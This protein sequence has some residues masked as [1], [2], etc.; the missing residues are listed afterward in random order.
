MKRKNLLQLGDV[1][2]TNPCVGWYG[3]AVVLAEWEKTEQFVPL[4]HIGIVDLAV[5]YKF[6]LSETNI[7]DLRILKIMQNIRMS[8]GEYASLREAACIGIYARKIDASIDV[9]GNIEIS[10]FWNRP[11]DL[12]VGDG[13]E[14]AFP[15]CGKIPSNLGYEAVNQWREVNDKDNWIIECDEARRSH[16]EMLERLKNAKL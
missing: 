8:T 13:S 6:E 11:L 7:S 1:I 15:L 2:R 5:K 10:G 9:I 16:Q 12:E 14:N 3:C 4:C